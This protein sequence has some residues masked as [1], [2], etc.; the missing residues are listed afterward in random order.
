MHWKQQQTFTMI[1]T[2]YGCLFEIPHEIIDTP[3]WNGVQ[4]NSK[5]IF[6]FKQKEVI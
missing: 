6:A 1:Q 5:R 4:E 3:P 2:L